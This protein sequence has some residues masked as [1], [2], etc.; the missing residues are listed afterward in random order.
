MLVIVTANAKEAVGVVVDPQL[1]EFV[2]QG[3]NVIGTETTLGA[4]GPHPA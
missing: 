2:N 1:Q 4:E 3:G